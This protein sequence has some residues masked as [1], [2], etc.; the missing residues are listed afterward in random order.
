MR[1]DLVLVRYPTEVRKRK[2]DIHVISSVVN[3]EEKMEIFGERG[4]ESP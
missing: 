4:N 1:E 3:F 2:I